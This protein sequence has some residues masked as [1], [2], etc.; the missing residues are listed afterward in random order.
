MFVQ[1]DKF[2]DAF[3]LHHKE[4]KK[5]NKIAEQFGDVR[6]KSQ[7][8]S[9]YHAYNCVNKRNF[10]KNQV[11]LTFFADCHDK[12]ILM[13]IVLERSTDIFGGISGSLD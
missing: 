1:I 6:T 11:E 8:I 7:L 4:K 13:H 10:D 5:W 12:L 9:D 3:Q 2:V